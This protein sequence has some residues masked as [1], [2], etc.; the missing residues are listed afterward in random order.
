MSKNVRETLYRKY[1]KAAASNA[2]VTPLLDE[3]LFGTDPAPYDKCAA[4]VADIW[5]ECHSCS[6][7]KI[8][9]VDNGAVNAEQYADAIAAA[10]EKCKKND[11]S[12]QLIAK[13]S[14]DEQLAGRTRQQLDAGRTFR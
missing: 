6:Q 12:G 11:P 4:I 10:T 14:G 1:H 5:K 9:A 13:F 7:N 3:M 8:G 2:P